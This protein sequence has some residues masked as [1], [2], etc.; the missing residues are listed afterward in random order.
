M[1]ISTI[2][3]AYILKNMDSS[4]IYLNSFAVMGQLLAFYMQVR[5]YMESYFLVSLANISSLITW[6]SK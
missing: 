6:F 1:I 5:R 2:I 4:F 3:Y